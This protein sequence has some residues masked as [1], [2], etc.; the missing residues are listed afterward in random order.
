MKSR[1][2]NNFPIL[3][4]SL[5]LLGCNQNFLIKEYYYQALSPINF[6][7]GDTITLKRDKFINM[8]DADSILTWKFLDGENINITGHISKYNQNVILPIYRYGMQKPNKLVVYNLKG[9]SDD[10]IYLT[11]TIIGSDWRD[12]K[13][14]Y[15]SIETIKFRI[16]SCKNVE[17]LNRSIDDFIKN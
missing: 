14:N 2:K 7:C 3:F 1:I 8:P 15:S 6:H 17:V 11:F 16:D 13:R 4:F 10:G 9:L 5:S 12:I